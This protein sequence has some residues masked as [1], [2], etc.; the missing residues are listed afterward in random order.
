MMVIAKKALDV[1]VREFFA[2]GK[3]FTGLDCKMPE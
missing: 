1:V 3:I 2:H